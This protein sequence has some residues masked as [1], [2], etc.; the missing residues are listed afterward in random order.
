M[1]RFKDHQPP[2]RKGS[3]IT[4]R[5]RDLKGLMFRINAIKRITPNKVEVEGGYYEGPLSSSGNTYTVRRI[6]KKWIVTH[7]EMQWIS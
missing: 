7:D 2:V 3:E 1:K 6:K 5:P 4:N